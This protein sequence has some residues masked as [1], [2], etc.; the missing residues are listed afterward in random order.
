MSFEHDDVIEARVISRPIP[1]C[2]KI[3]SIMKIE[4][5]RFRVVPG[6]LM[7]QR[8]TPVLYVHGRSLTQDTRSIE[9]TRLVPQA[10]NQINTKLRRS[11]EEMTQAPKES[12]PTLQRLHCDPVRH[13]WRF[14]CAISAHVVPEHHREAFRYRHRRESTGTCKRAPA[15]ARCRLNSL[16]TSPRRVTPETLRFPGRRK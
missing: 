7:N 10:H 5:V 14:R 1:T 6:E 11:P 13:H 4:S 15:R 8:R 2:M 9:E 16:R 12:L 3:E